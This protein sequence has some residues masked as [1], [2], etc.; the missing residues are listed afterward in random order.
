V[1]EDWPQLLR[2]MII[3]RSFDDEVVA[4]FAHAG[5][6]T[7]PE[8]CNEG[9]VA[10]LGSL[11]R[12][13]DTVA[14][15]EPAHL[16]VLAGGAPLAATLAE[17]LTLPQGLCGGKS[18]PAELIDA[19]R[20][21]FGV[22]EPLGKAPELGAGAAL[23]T[24]VLGQPGV[25]VAVVGPQTV[26]SGALDGAL[27]MIA[28]WRL[29]AVVVVTRRGEPGADAEAPDGGTGG[30]VPPGIGG[31]DGAP[32]SAAGVERIVVDRDD[33]LALREAMARAIE[34]ARSGAGPTLVEA[35]VA[36]PTDQA[37]GGAPGSVPA[38]P[39]LRLALAVLRSGAAMP[40]AL[41]E[42][43]DRS[44]A[45]VRAARDLVRSWAAAPAA[46]VAGSAAESLSAGATPAAPA[47]P[48]PPGGHP[49]PPP[50]ASSPPVPPPP[51]PPAPSWVRPPASQTDGPA[52]RG[53][54]P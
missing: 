9:V 30:A 24:Q 1:P 25:T 26:R 45:E 50:F 4:A 27:A 31:P 13:G 22:D 53:V 17:L 46:P 3:V 43:R 41:D 6:V 21:A 8:R 20:A 16:S 14:S 32:Y 51:P 23:A 36:R 2:T 29:P 48:E 49:A 34:R 35:L 39:I 28:E 19:E 37:P 12:P 52:D 47:E 18:G 44:R 15:S 11:L 38:D 40:E 10:V 42:L 7:A 54:S 5:G 33:V